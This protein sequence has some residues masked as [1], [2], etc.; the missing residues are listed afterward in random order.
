MQNIPNIADY[1]L[2]TENVVLWD[3]VCAL[4]DLDFFI[5]K[6]QKNPARRLR[7]NPTKFPECNAIQVM[8]L[9]VIDKQWLH[10]TNNT[11]R[12]DF[13]FVKILSHG[14]PGSIDEGLTSSNHRT[15]FRPRHQNSDTHSEQPS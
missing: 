5:P 4:P 6:R 3:F 1:D 8:I 2:A 7:T 11:D 14:Q 9:G 10:G 13:N 15:Y 12:R